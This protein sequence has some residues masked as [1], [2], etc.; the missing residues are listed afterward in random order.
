MKY[1]LMFIFFQLSLTTQ[2]QKIKSDDQIIDKW[3][4]AT[5]NVLCYP[6]ATKNNL[7]LLDSALKIGRIDSVQ[8]HRVVRQIISGAVTGTAIWFTYK[9]YNFLLS[10]RHVL[11]DT[12]LGQGRCY[13]DIHV[14]ENGSAVSIDYLNKAFL[15]PNR[16]AIVEVGTAVSI[17]EVFESIYKFSSPEK[18][19]AIVNLDSSYHSLGL[20]HFLRKGG[21]KPVDLVDIDTLFQTKNGESVMAIGYPNESITKIKDEQEL[22]NKH[23]LLTSPFFTRPFITRGKVFDIR[24]ENNS[25]E[26]D[27]FTYH[28]F[29]GGPIINKKGKLIGITHG[30]NPSKGISPGGNYFE[31][32]GEFMKSSL[33]MPL[34][35]DV[36]KQVKMLPYNLHLQIGN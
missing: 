8:H 3:T 17:I 15:K 26:V 4:K 30:Y 23:A 27:I 25:F 31:Y 19:I 22:P 33:I 28:G 21:Y 2:G 16:T 29:S 14:V 7:L 9:K 24:K 10:A 20:F 5:L 35:G 34:L 36:L 12:S 13:Q 11:E 6:K 18:D 1:L 32:H